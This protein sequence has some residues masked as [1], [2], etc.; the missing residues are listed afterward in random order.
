MTVKLTPLQQGVPIVDRE[1][2]PTPAFMQP[3]QQ[4]LTA[5]KDAVNQLLAL[6][7]IQAAL[8]DLDTAT[9]AAQTAADAAN[10]A[11]E[12]TA[13]AS[14]LATSYVTGLTLSAQDAGASVTLTISNHTR[15]YGDGTSVAV[16][17]GTITGVPYST[18]ARVF[19]DQPSRAGGSVTYQWTS[20]A[21][22]AAQTGNR[23]SV[24]AVTTPA[25]LDPPVSGNPIYPPGFALP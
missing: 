17:G 2:R 12:A 21:E 7:E 5:L 22:T 24:G 13:A 14:S 11:A 8:E 18:I 4:Q 25:A 19:Y 6:P 10:A 1:G 23:H 15:V 20:S 3:L 9:Q 16:T